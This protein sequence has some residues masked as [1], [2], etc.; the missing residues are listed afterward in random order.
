MLEAEPPVAVAEVTQ[1]A[2][3]GTLIAHRGALCVTRPTLTAPPRAGAVPDAPDPG[4]SDQPA[5]WQSPLPVDAGRSVS[6]R[7]SRL[8]GLW[9]LAIVATGSPVAGGPA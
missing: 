8:T 7:L 5:L 3:D 2:A 9:R 1:T 4:P 6:S